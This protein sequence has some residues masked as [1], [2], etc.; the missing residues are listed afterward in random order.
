MRLKIV[1]LIAIQFGIF[2]GIVGCLVYSRFE[3]AKPRT[4]AEIKQHATERAV[5]REPASE[6]GD[7]RANPEPAQLAPGQLAPVLSNE[8]SAEAVERYRAEAT[9]L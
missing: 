7:Q 1:N 6:S 9:R 3:S 4:A 2:I 5:V 8:Y